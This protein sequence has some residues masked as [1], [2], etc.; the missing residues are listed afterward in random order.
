MKSKSSDSPALVKGAC[1]KC[2]EPPNDT[3]FWPP[4]TRWFMTFSNLKGKPAVCERCIALALG[5]YAEWEKK[6]R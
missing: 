3:G 5:I 6:R 2:G 1:V 4:P